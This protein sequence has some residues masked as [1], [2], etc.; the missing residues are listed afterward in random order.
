MFGFWTC[1]SMLVTEFVAHKSLKE[2]IINYSRSFSL[3]FPKWNWA[4]L[5]WSSWMWPCIT[6]PFSLLF[7]ANFS[8]LFSRLQ[9][10]KNSKARYRFWVHDREGLFRVPSSTDYTLA[11]HGGLEPATF[12][13]WNDPLARRANLNPVF[14]WIWSIKLTLRIMMQVPL[15]VKNGYLEAMTTT[16]L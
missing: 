8:R 4:F 16:F 9:R 2:N 13:N 3:A 12:G 6:Q 11:P 15:A 5:T 10:A 14:S 7:K 1:F